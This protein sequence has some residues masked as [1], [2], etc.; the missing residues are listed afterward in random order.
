MRSGLAKKGSRFVAVYCGPYIIISIYVSP[1]LSLREFNSILDELTVV[2]SHRTNKII[3]GGDFNAKASLWN[4]GS[5]DG[6]GLLL[7]RWA[8]ERDLRILN[9]GNA[10]TCVRPQ[11]KSIIDLTWTSPDLLRLVRKWRVREDVESLSDHLY[12]EYDIHTDR[13]EMPLNKSLP[14]KW[15]S[16]KM[17]NDLF[18]AVMIW[19]GEGPKP[20]DRNDVSRMT[21]WLDQTMEEACDVAASRVGPGGPRRQTYWWQDSVA[22]LR[23]SCIRARRLW[24][25]AKKRKRAHELVVELGLGYKTKRITELLEPHIL[26]K[27]LDSLFPRNTG[28]E[29]RRGWSDFC[30]SDDWSV[31]LGEAHRVIRKRPSSSTKAPGPDGF[32]LG[33]EKGVADEIL[34]WIRFT[35]ELCLKKGEFPTPWK[36]ANL[37]L[38]PKGDSQEMDTLALPKV[39]PICLINEIAKAFERILVERISS[40]QTEHP[41]SDLSVNQFGFRKGRSTCDAL[42]HLK[43]ITNNVVRL[44]GFAIVV[45]IDIKNAFNSIL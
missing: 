25:R 42:L 7:T 1:R 3:I 33:M 24:Q 36:C 8:A 41:E 15:S 6:R 29:T 28:V 35:F 4:A 26:E 40:W 18:L 11:G 38:I 23:G 5:T 43:M 14:R 37:V 19:R 39:R 9:T 44:G 17:D 31:S 16:K 34:E 10:P 13:P 12:I 32:R 27:L 45:A 22:E 20:E 30:W 2:L 21:V